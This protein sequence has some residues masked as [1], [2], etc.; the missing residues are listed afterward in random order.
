M[1]Q[2]REQLLPFER[3]TREPGHSFFGYYDLQPWSGN[4]EY[5]LCGRVPFM[6]RMPESCDRM[7]LGMIRQ[8]DDCFIPLAST[9]AWNFQQGAMLQWNPLAPD[10]EIIYNAFISGAYRA[11][12]RNIRTGAERLLPHPVANV[13]QNGRYAL[14]FHFGRLYD[15]RPGYGYCQI[16]D[17]NEY[18]RA[19]ENDGIYRIDMIRGTEKMI[20]SLKQVQE[21]FNGHFHPPEGRKML[22]N[23]ITFNPSGTRFLALARSMPAPDETWEGWASLLFTADSDG[24]N[25]H[26]FDGRGNASHYAWRDDEHLVIFADNGY[27]KKPGMKLCLLT[28]KT[29]DVEFIDTDYFT[30]DGHCSYCPADKNWLLYDS[31]PDEEGYRRL[32][33]YNLKEGKGYTLARLLSLK[34]SMQISDEIRCDLHPRWNRDG[35]MISFD[36]IHEGVRHVY[37]MDLSPLTGIGK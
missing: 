13:A 20:L 4:G 9:Y 3:M 6:D 33:L 5:H 10:D 22:V 23:H 36:S 37:R 11:V 32:L 24:G 17:E 8:Y 34:K 30:F 21:I 31:Y 27:Q 7:E 19:P 26:V 25:V 29:Q 14:S 15:F 16:P 35:S 12:V 2:I 28:D 1:R 18:V